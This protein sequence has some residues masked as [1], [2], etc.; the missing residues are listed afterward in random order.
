MYDKYNDYELLSYISECNEDATDI[1]LKKYE[2]LIVST[3]KKLLKGMENFGLDIND[4]IQEGRLGLLKAS[5]TFSESKDTLFYTYAKTCIERKMY[6]LVK[7][8]RR[9]KH[10]ILNE[11]I[12]IDVD[13]DKGE[14]KEL[15]YLLKDETENH[16]QLL[17]NE[18]GKKELQNIINSKLNDIEIQV[19]ELKL[20]GFE[21]KEISEI[22]DCD[23]K[24]IDNTLQRIKQ[25]LKETKKCS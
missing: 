17:L 18:E 6:D 8:T 3:A 20:K 16:E 25:K 11:S 21:N 22:L 5:E 15:D 24:K 14:Y 1:L 4:L 12:P 7:S 2:P 19:L 9:V 23:Y 10:K 13:D